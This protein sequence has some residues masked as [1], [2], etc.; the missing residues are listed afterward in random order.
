MLKGH[1]LLFQYARISVEN[2]PKKPQNMSTVCKSVAVLMSL[3]CVKI[4]NEGS[5]LTS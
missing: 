3:Y 1:F 4:S 5:M 2:V